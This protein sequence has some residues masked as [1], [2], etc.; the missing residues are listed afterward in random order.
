[1]GQY[2]VPQNV[3]AEDKILGPLTL[4]QFIYAMMG[5]GWAIISF[6]IFQ[7]IL[8]VMIVVGAPPT[9]LLML[10]AFYTKDGQNFEQLLVALV[11]FYYNSRHRIWRKEEI[12]ESFHITPRK[13]AAEQTQRDPLVVRGQL[14][15]LASMIDSRG[16]NL[17]PAGQLVQPDRLVAPVATPNPQSQLVEPQAS[18]DILDLQHS[19]LAQNLASLI[20]EATSDVRAEAIEQMTARSKAAPAAKV[21][22]TSSISVTTANPGDIMKLAM[23]RDDLTVSQLAASATRSTALQEGQVAEIPHNG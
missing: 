11:G 23:E 21:P 6:A 8:I 18:E 19:P 5:F 10:L 3:E 2:K 9:I 15:N 13:V 20:Q 7:K 1:M 12:I 16:W 4:K 22:A 14:E 17:E